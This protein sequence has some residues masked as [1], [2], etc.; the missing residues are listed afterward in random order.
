MVAG[1]KELS[2][3]NPTDG[4]ARFTL[5]RQC[6]PCWRWRSAS[7][8]TDIITAGLGY[9]K[10]FHPFYPGLLQQTKPGSNLSQRQK[11]NSGMAPSVGK[12]MVSLLRLWR[13]DWWIRCRVGR[14]PTATP[15]VGRWQNSGSESNNNVVIMQG[16]T[17]WRLEKLSQNLAA[18]CYPSHTTAPIQHP[19]MSTYLEPWLMQ[20]AIRS[21]GLLIWFVRWNLSEQSR[22]RYR[23]G[24][25]ALVR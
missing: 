1:R 10:G 11:G 14:Q 4:A 15:T 6:C 12:V 25:H 22:A 5:L 7:A 2:F 17:V 20:S 23:Q 13:S 19:Q 8:R 21:L 9:R 3:R 18:Q 16:R 24:I